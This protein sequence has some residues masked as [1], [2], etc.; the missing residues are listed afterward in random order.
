MENYIKDALSISELAGSLERVSSDDNRDIETY[1]Q[2]EILDEAKWVLSEFFEGGHSSNEAL[3]G[4]WGIEAKKEAQKEVRYLK[5]F[6][7][8]YA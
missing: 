2:Q 6:I 5:A 3:N 8:K 1:T 7:K 4:E